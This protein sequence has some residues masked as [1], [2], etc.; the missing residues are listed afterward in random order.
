MTRK[1]FIQK[2][3]WR[4]ASSLALLG[5]IVYTV[6]HVFGST[7]GGLMRERVQKI[8]HADIVSGQAYLFRD[9][10]VLTVPHAG[11][12]NDLAES[13]SKV[14]KGVA[15]AEVWDGYSEEL[16]PTAQ[17][18]LDR[19]NRTV[20]LLEDSIVAADST[21]SNAE[22]YRKD[23]MANYLAIK[24]ALTAG[25]WSGLQGLEDDM[26]ALLNRHA[27]LIGATD[28]VPTLLASVKAERSRLLMGSVTTIRN[29]GSSGYFYGHTRVDGYEA[30][31]TL[32]ALEGLTEKSFEELILSEPK[33]TDEFAVGKIVT[34]SRW[35]LA[36]GFDA[37]AKEL[38]EASEA[39]TFTFPQNRDT[40]LIMTCT[41]LLEKADGGLIAVFSSN[42][43]PRD[44]TYLR[45]QSVQIEVGRYT[46]YYIKESA[47]HTLNGVEGVYIFRESTVWFRRIDVIY[48]GDGYCIAAEYTDQ[49]EGY[50][51]LNDIIVTSGEDLYDGRVFK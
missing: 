9:E 40:S 44:F 10:R 43:V 48:R 5:L 19:L 2:Y 51:A 41:R 8:T 50:L 7:S 36:I 22:E 49:G 15:V 4:F 14:S 23:A 13:G 20:A 42:E 33:G 47:L 11:V 29:E 32:S 12:I 37:S 35:Y 16:V 18:E 1:A 39:Y 21:L 3:F 27:T 46:G 25:D 34:G 24:K 26:L 45:S 28:S 31:F 30:L 38:F 17:I 6:Y